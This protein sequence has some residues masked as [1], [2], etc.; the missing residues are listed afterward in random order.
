MG[1]FIDLTGQRFGRWI[2]IDKISIIKRNR[3]I[4]RWLC[5]CDCGTERSINGNDLRMGRSNSCGCSNIINLIGQ[6]FGS[7][8]VVELSH[9]NKNGAYWKCVCDCGGE[10]ITSSHSLKK[11]DC[12]TC[13]CSTA[14]LFKR[15]PVIFDDLTGKIF[16]KLIVIKLSR[17]CKNN[18]YWWVKCECG[19]E[20]EIKG[21]SL[22]SKNPTMSCGCHRKENARN[23]RL[24][25]YG[26]A[27]FNQ[28]FKSYKLNAKNRGFE[29][30]LNKEKFNKLTHQ[31]CFYCGCEPSNICISQSENGD[32]I[33][34][35]IDRIDSTKGYTEDNVVTCCRRCNEAKMS[36]TQPDFLSWIDRVHS[37]IH[38][39]ESIS[40]NISQIFSAY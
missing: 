35:G 6:R 23:L 25:E 17:M 20:K 39:N 33:Y 16:G 19:N 22:K 10:K 29:F 4:I 21:S 7:L 38:R 14:H 31:N 5:R 1:K 37:H 34:N 27:T 24:K 12:K 18:D 3:K 32:Y 36:E 8:L 30:Q 13:G 15:N 11:G 28:V 9:T 40:V 2:V 26:L